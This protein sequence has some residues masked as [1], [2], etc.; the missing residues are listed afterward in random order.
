M[1]CRLRAVAL[2][3]V[4][5]IRSAQAIASVVRC[6]V[7]LASRIL[8]PSAT[9]MQR[10]IR[11]VTGLTPMS[12]GVL[13]GPFRARSVATASPSAIAAGLPT[14]PSGFSHPPLAVV[15]RVWGSERQAPLTTRRTFGGRP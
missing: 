1:L 13:H 11:D 15:E 12:Q 5:P 3:L 2:D 7:P 10:P 9:E 6:A 14:L 4:L 8:A